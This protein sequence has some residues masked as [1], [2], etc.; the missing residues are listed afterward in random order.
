MA[1]FA[2]REPAASLAVGLASSP[3]LGST[4]RGGADRSFGAELAGRVMPDS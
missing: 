4:G 3:L 1:P 2:E